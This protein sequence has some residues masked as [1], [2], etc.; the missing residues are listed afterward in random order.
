MSLLYIYILLLAAC[1]DG[2]DPLITVSARVGSTVILPCK[3][4]EVF[5][6]TSLI[7]WKMNNELVI[8]RSINATSSGSGYEGRVDIPVDEL[9]KGNCSLVLKDVRITEDRFYKTFTVENVDSTNPTEVK[10]ITRVRLSVYEL[11]TDVQHRAPVEPLE[12]DMVRIESEGL[13]QQIVS[14]AIQISARVGS[15]AVLPCEWRNLSIQTHHVE[16]YVDSEIVL[17]RDDEELFVGVGYKGRLDV[18][19]DELLKGN[20]SLVLKN[21][22]VTDALVY[23]SAMVLPETKKSVLVQT[24]KLS[25]DEMKDGTSNQSGEAG[26]NCPRPLIL[27][28]SFLMYL[29]FSS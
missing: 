6:Q 23:R 28:I 29:L 3:L 5:T 8:E 24:V 16:W 20:C 27:I 7:R 21:V 13:S 2:E 19:K 1:V 11:A 17:E 18:P 4:T 26:I 10:E 22:S 25:V 14:E 9:R 15:T 12:Q